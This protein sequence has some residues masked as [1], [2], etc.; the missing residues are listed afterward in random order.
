[1]APYFA[2]KPENS[3]RV[4]MEYG[5]CFWYGVNS[6]FGGQWQYHLR[7]RK[8]LSPVCTVPNDLRNLSQNV[9]NTAA[10]SHAGI[11][12]D[13]KTGG[14][15]IIPGKGAAVKFCVLFLHSGPYLPNG[16]LKCLLQRI[17]V[18]IS[19]ADR[20]PDFLG[21]CQMQFPRREIMV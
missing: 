4:P 17:S 12:D 18:Y 1:M 11:T 2:D 3:R 6:C 13:R 19:I 10:L 20:A 9:P 5:G 8:G 21:Q 16:F 7:L 14:Y 15:R